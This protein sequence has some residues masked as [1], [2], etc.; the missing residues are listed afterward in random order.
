MTSTTFFFEF[1]PLLAFILLAVNL[2]FAPHNSYPEKDSAFEC[3]FH[4]FLGQNRTQFSISFFVFALLFLLFDLEIL[5][6]YPYVVSAYTNSIYGLVVMLIFFLVLTL[7]FAFELG[8]NALKINSRQTRKLNLVRKL[9]NATY[10]SPSPRSAVFPLQSGLLLP[11]C[12]LLKKNMNM[13]MTNEIKNNFQ[14]PHPFHLVSPSPRPI[15]I[16]SSL[17]VLNTKFLGLICTLIGMFILLLLLIITPILIF[18]FSF[19][20]V[21]NQY[22]LGYDFSETTINSYSTLLS[23]LYDIFSKVDTLT[24]QLVT[25]ISYNYLHGIFFILGCFTIIAMFYNFIIKSNILQ[26]GI[27]R[28]KNS[29]SVFSFYFITEVLPLVVANIAKNINDNKY[30]LL[31]LLICTVPAII[32]IK[33]LY[34]IFVP[35]SGSINANLYFSVML[36][37]ILPFMNFATLVLRKCISYFS[38]SSI[39]NN[40][41]LSLKDFYNTIT[42]SNFL[43]ICAWYCFFAQ[44]IVPHMCF[45]IPK[46]CSGFVCYSGKLISTI[47]LPHGLEPLGQLF[48]FVS[49]PVTRSHFISSLH[50]STPSILHGVAKT[51]R[52]EVKVFSDAIGYKEI[53]YKANSRTIL[54]KISILM[55]E[56]GVFR[57][58]KSTQYLVQPS[59]IMSAVSG[60]NIFAVTNVTNT[61]GP[62]KPK[63]FSFMGL[64]SHINIELLDVIKT[65]GKNNISL[66]N[67]NSKDC[68]LVSDKGSVIHSYHDAVIAYN[69]G[70]LNGLA[71]QVD[72]LNCIEVKERD[73]ENI[74]VNPKDITPFVT[75]DLAAL[76]AGNGYITRNNSK[77]D[78]FPGINHANHDDM[79]ANLARDYNRGLIVNMMR[80]PDLPIL[81]TTPDNENQGIVQQS[82]QLD[83]TLSDAVQSQQSDQLDETLSDAVQSQQS[84]ELDETFSDAV[85]SQQSEE[86][87]E[88]FSDAVQSQQSEELDAVQSQQSEESDETLCEAVQHQ[89]PSRVTG[90]L[91]YCRS[92]IDSLP[93]HQET[94]VSKSG[95]AEY[96]SDISVQRFSLVAGLRETKWPWLILD[97]RFEEMHKLRYGLLTSPSTR[98][99]VYQIHPNYDSAHERRQILLHVL[100]FLFDKYPNLYTLTGTNQDGFVTNKLTNQTFDIKSF[101]PLDLCSRLTNDDFNIVRK[102]DGEY[103]LIAS[104]TLLP[105]AWKLEDKIG[106]TIL[107]LHAPVTLW[108]QKLSERVFK[109]FDRIIDKTIDTHSRDNMF[110]QMS[111]NLFTREP[112]DIYWPVEKDLIG[113]P[114]GYQFEEMHLRRE[115]QS[116]Y[117]IPAPN[118]NLD[119]NS[120]VFSFHTVIDRMVDLSDSDLTKFH[121]AVTKWPDEAIINGIAQPGIASYKGRNCW[122]PVVN[123]YMQ[124]RGLLPSTDP[125]GTYT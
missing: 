66:I 59:S 53:T 95:T 40:K 16:S 83:E 99:M 60:Q 117:R 107:Q 44:L 55:V 123:K 109:A 3:G 125:M 111:S 65:L 108:E 88:T 103:R 115:Y 100:N 5:L 22:P 58:A 27:V 89:Y 41:T 50:S 124:T 13:N 15:L 23:I 91:T 12:C 67:I 61:V 4:S 28:K 120:L 14:Q 32:G 26:G 85:Q 63:I 31:F 57:T 118:S 82:D 78:W 21:N 69:M 96:Y 93:T 87:D 46:I 105:A 70:T 19:L 90:D 110:V 80:L 74:S 113:K 68:F 71:K 101:E 92:L 7:G 47:K 102:V 119:S 54:S 73:R 116:F 6:V 79:L 18:M 94:L 43:L 48:Y 29:F 81:N 2:V 45:F 24:T 112:H 98:H 38:F 104:T 20:L 33:Y 30:K 35:N 97:D 77:S 56:S 49:R 17:F 9:T 114:G 37:I 64:G 52:I 51:S 39:D 76:S 75:S 8:K 72:S 62:L 25:Y 106:S 86:L 11:D 122:G 42:Y 36:L 34:F 121:Q 84:E 1:I 10:I